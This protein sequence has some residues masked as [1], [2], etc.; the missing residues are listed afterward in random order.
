MRGIR[1]MPSRCVKANTAADWPWVSACTVSASTLK[2]EHGYRDDEIGTHAG[3][4]DTSLQLV[5]AP[6]MVR[7]ERLR[8]YPKLG[9]G[10]GVY[11]GDPHHASAE[12][13][14]LGIDAIMSRTITAIRN[15]TAGR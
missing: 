10:D 3:L 11:G 12:L 14:R 2:R 5:V 8:N 15:E 7:M 1:L 13:G 6:Q 4:A 9:P